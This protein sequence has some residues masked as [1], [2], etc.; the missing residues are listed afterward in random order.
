LLSFYRATLERHYST[1][2]TMWRWY[3]M[4]FVP[5]L[6]FIMA[7]MVLVAVERRQAHL[8]GRHL[9]SGMMGIG[10]LIYRSTQ[11][12]A[13]QIRLRIDTLASAEERLQ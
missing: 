2:Q 9:C 1:I 12:M 3:A 10:L 5:A 7:G 8:A 11:D 6:L 13:R 4:P